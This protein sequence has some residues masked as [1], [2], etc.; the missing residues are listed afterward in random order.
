MNLRKICIILF[1][2]GIICLGFSIYAYTQ[3]FG[4]NMLKINSKLG[5]IYAISYRYTFVISVFLL[6]IGTTIRFMLKSK[7][8]D[9]NTKVNSC[10]EKEENTNSTPH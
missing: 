8:S 6:L 5:Y 7:R 10:N 1:I 4:F 3:T 9:T 2:I